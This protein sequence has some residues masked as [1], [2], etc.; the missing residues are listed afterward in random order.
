MRR[1]ILVTVLIIVAFFAIVGG[2]GLWVWNGYMYYSTDDAQVS[3][4]IANAT[5]PA[6]GQLTSLSVKVGDTV[7]SGQTIGS[8]TPAAANANASS[9][10]ITSPISGVVV[11]V[12]GVQNQNVTP[13]VALVSVMDPSSLTVTAY[14]DEASINNIKIDQDVDIKVDAYNDTTF[15]GK[16]KQVVQA[17]AG[18]FSLLPTQDNASGNFTKVGQRI[19]VI[20]T[21]TGF[22]GK[23]VVPGMNAVTTI[24]IH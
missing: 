12:A 23:D 13:G 21:V 8:I 18:S 9:I 20:I 10:N 6:A 22:G 3:G 5:S 19:P 7:T 24:H 11:Q 14:V 4:T 2:A 16:V 15:T 17:T 1:T